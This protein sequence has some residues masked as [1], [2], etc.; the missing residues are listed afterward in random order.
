MSN[1]IEFA[2]PARHDRE[3]FAFTDSLD[4]PYST[5]YRLQSA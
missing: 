5:K 1:D 3:A 4:V 2:F